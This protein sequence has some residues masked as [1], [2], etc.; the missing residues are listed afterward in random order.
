MIPA[1]TCTV[2]GSTGALDGGVVGLGVFFLI[3]LL[4]GAHC[5]GMCG[6]LV[7]T[8]ADRMRASESTDRR[9]TLSVRQVRQHAL[10]NLGRTASYALIGGLFGLAGSVVF[11]SAGQLTTVVREVNIVVGATIGVLIIATGVTYLFRGRTLTLPG[12]SMLTPIT[13]WVQTRL[14]SRI[15]RYVGGPKIVGLGALH[16]LLPCPILYPAFLYAFVQASPIAGVASLAALGFGTIPSLF[17]YGTLFQSLSVS[18]RTKLHRLLG[19]AFVLLGYIPLQ[20]ALMLVGIP[21]PHPHIPFY[22][23]I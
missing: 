5:L 16:G 13:G 20:H 17:L 19:V 14:F 21:L 11:V 15:D 18:T 6:P 23:P 7:T 9:G 8:Y 1:Q 10:F 2:P 3:G 12:E 22:Q 4:G